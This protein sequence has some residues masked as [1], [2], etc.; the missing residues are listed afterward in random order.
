MSDFSIQSANAA[1]APT[2][3]ALIRALADYEKLEAGFAL[4]EA[5]VR[6]DMLGAVCHT[7]LAEMN[8]AVVGIAVWFWIYKSFGAARG[9]FVEDLY[10][11][12]ECRGR[13]LGPALLAHLPGKARNAGGFMEWQVLDWNAPSI[14]FYNSL[15]AE[16]RDGW[17]SYRLK[18]DALIR[19]AS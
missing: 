17:T 10:V 14:A 18:G 1:D 11:R 6:R 2:V 3:V 5:A 12:P 19:L 15:G 8:G 13:G 7:E 16:P 4:D 9:L